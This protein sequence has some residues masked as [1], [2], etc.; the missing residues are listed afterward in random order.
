M[1]VISNNYKSNQIENLD[2]ILHTHGI[3][4]DSDKDLRACEIGGIDSSNIS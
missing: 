3:F 1:S 4:D 2:F